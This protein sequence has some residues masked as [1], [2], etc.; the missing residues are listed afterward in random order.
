MT[1]RQPTAEPPAL[2]AEPPSQRKHSWSRRNPAGP[3][4]PA[5]ADL[6]GHDW[7]VACAR[8][9][10]KARM[11]RM[12]AEQRSALGRLGGLKRW[13]PGEPN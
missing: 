10:G 6:V 7:F 8:L 13:H 1:E 5:T 12:T 3:P 4:N 2:A 9:G 11:A